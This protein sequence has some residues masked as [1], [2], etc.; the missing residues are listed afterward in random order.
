MPLL[1]LGSR[2]VVVDRH[3]HGSSRRRSHVTHQVVFI[4]SKE[5]LG[6]AELLQGVGAGNETLER[7]HAQA[8][9][10]LATLCVLAARFSRL[11]LLG[12]LRVLM[13][14]MHWP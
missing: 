13:H 12:S 9:S 6:K 14:L 1:H 3:F 11:D 10:F 7:Q 4:P 8:V 5:F 2:Q